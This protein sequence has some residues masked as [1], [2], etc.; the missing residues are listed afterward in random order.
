MSNFDVPKF[1]LSFLHPRYLHT[2]LGVLLMYLVSW[3]PYRLQ[4]MLGRKLGLLVMKILKSRKKVA[5]RNLE[6]CFPDLS[7]AERE[8]LLKENFEHAGLAVFET[9]IAWFWP[10]WRVRRHIT[11]KGF[12]KLD[13]I[14]EDGRGVML[15]AIHSYNIEITARAFG[16]LTKGYGI[17]RPNTNPVFEW[18]QYLGR[19]R[20]NGLI[21][22]LD[23]KQTIRRLKKG[24][25]VWLAPDHDYGRHRYTWAPF[26]AV[27][28]ACTTT[29]T[30]LYARASQCRVIPL[31]LVRNSEGTGYTLTLE[32]ELEDFPYGD[33][34]AAAERVNKA[35]ERSI[36]KAPEQYMWLHKRFKSRPDGEPPAYD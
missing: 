2:W 6:L 36:M 3:L 31:S 13:A 30:S 27:D 7:V 26:F 35:I 19:T 23:V 21:D 29:G 9:C 5:E 11:Y 25:V 32:P 14:R 22:R 18:F 12:E 8:K 24:D 28:K 15:I 34:Q 33:E 10:D 16:L 1:S 20:Q 17:Y 4:R